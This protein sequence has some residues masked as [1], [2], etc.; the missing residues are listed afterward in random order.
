MHF[1]FSNHEDEYIEREA[2]FLDLL[3]A[4]LFVAHCVRFLRFEI[5][6]RARWLSLPHFDLRKVNAHKATL[7][8]RVAVH[9]GL[10][11]DLRR[12]VDVA[13]YSSIV[14]LDADG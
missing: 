12:R 8:A 9:E 7:R 3:L 11:A 13:P 1:T 10:A 4:Y 2:Q 5:G 6:P 14:L